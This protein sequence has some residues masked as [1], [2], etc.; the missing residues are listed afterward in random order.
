MMFIR[1]GPRTRSRFQAL[2]VVA[3]LLAAG[4][5]AALAAEPVAT[6]PPAPAQSAPPAQPAIP[7]STNAVLGY[8]RAWSLSPPAYRDALSSVA[9]ASVKEKLQEKATQAAM[10][11][12]DTTEM[13]LRAA[14]KPDADWGVE[15]SQGVGALLPEL[16][17][18]RFST[19]LLRTTAA[20]ALQ[21]TP[22]DVR[23]AGDCVVATIRLARHT[24]AQ[25]L[26]ISSLVAAAVVSAACE[27]ASAM[28]ELKRLDAHSREAMLTDLRAMQEPD[29]LGF[30]ASI[31]INE[32]NLLRWITDKVQAERADP[33]RVWK[34][35]GAML[36][37]DTAP[38][39]KALS[40]EALVAELK[41]QD[42]FFDALV[43]AWTTAGA[44]AAA[45]LAALEK[46]AEAGEF[47]TFT[48]IFGPT[49]TRAKQGETK[50]LATIAQTITALEN[51]TPPN[52][53]PPPRP[54]KTLEQL[55]I[56]P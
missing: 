23:R 12:S 28:I 9:P 2:S 30:R 39:V 29:A 48:Q 10:D 51:Y 21:E 24:A 15:Y 52:D 43:A 22:P 6:Q 50:A 18:V 32:R 41:Q 38:T 11:L 19:R 36:G 1:T 34:A 3:T 5:L 44:D 56:K 16:G 27:D 54:A 40:E 26:L 17:L 4:N 13:L 35:L 20:S 33:R 25:R 42:A 31:N 8:W 7:E 14:A 45:A 49:V 47:G 53:L 37:K 46:R 55:G